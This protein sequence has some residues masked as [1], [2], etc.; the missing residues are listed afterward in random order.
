MPDV[1]IKEW[2]DE[3]LDATLETVYQVFGSDSWADSITWP[4]HAIT[5]ITNKTGGVLYIKRSTVT[6][7]ATVDG[8]VSLSADAY[9][10][11]LADGEAD[12]FETAPGQGLCVYAAASGYIYANSVY[13]VNNAS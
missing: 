1:I 4:H 5:T 7:G 3:E 10:Y 9:T 8:A 6:P 11:S 12:D 2:K 13:K